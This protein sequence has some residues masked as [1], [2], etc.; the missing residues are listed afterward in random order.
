[1]GE[2]RT[3]VLLGHRLRALGQ[4]IDDLDRELWSL[5]AVLGRWGVGRGAGSL[6]SPPSQPAGQ[7]HRSVH[8]DGL[9]SS[10]GHHFHSVGMVIAGMFTRYRML[11]KVI[12]S[13]NPLCEK[14]LICIF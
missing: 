3:S 2:S 6:Y 5:R 11:S 9:Q 10:C 13:L 1:M 4:G 7:G 14:G 12:P 8:L